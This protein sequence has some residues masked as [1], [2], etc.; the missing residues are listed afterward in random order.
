[1]GV[2]ECLAARGAA[3]LDLRHMLIF[4]CWHPQLI[5]HGEKLRGG[6]PGLSADGKR[7]AKCI[8][9]IFSRGELKAE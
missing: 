6:K 1:M 7:R 4:S 9:R 2:C 8:R 3:Y 5:R